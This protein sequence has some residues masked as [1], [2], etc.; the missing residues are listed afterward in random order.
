MGNELEGRLTGGRGGSA[1]G[2]DTSTAQYTGGIV[3]YERDMSNLS[4]GPNR[5]GIPDLAH[6]VRASWI[7]ISELL[8]EKDR[9]KSWT[10]DT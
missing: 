4:P 2:V 8:P 10:M 6:F 9:T 5:Q 3:A 1:S 7:R